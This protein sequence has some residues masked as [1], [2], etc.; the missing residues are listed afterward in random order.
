VE[1]I[2]ELMLFLMVFFAYDPAF[3]ARFMV[4]RLDPF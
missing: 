2:G 3:L 1:K 4:K